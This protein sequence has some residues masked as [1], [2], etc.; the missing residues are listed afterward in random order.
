MSPPV[1]PFAWRRHVRTALR[2]RSTIAA[3]R[4]RDRR[5]T[6]VRTATSTALEKPVSDLLSRLDAVE[7][8]LDRLESQE[9]VAGVPAA[10]GPD[11]AAEP[12]DESPAGFGMPD[13]G[14]TVALLGRT[15]FVLAGAFLLRALTDS[16]RLDAGLGVMLGFAFAATWIA[17][18]DRAGGRGQAASAR[19]PR[20]GVRPH[21]LPAALRGDDP[22]PFP[23]PATAAAGLGG[24]TAIALAVA[25]ATAPAGPGLGRVGRRAGDGR[26]AGAGHRGTWP[27]RALP[28]AARRRS[29]CGSATCSS[30]P[31]CAGPWPSSP[32][33]RSSFC[34]FAP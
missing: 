31:C 7:R 11:E 21:R 3:D 8:R 28:G 1:W 14:S 12:A 17:M 16:G 27:L 10:G 18:A 13:V 19:I 32:T 30:G 6:P 23:Q 26:G 24:C 25:V 9:H 22:L 33:W 2:D 29:R 15:L 20:L 34:P 5:P 4:S